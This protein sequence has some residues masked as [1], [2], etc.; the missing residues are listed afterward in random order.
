MSY[1]L[2]QLPPVSTRGVNLRTSV[3]RPWS[4]LLFNYQAAD[5]R[6]SWLIYDP[7]LDAPRRMNRDVILG[8]GLVL[9]IS[10]SFWTGIGLAIAQVWK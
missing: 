5:F 1:R 9:L 6:R 3:P 4:A 8:M 2:L 7:E 10:A